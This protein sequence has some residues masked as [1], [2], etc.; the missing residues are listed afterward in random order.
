MV[1]SYIDLARQLNM[2]NLILIFYNNQ[3]ELKILREK[4]KMLITIESKY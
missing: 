4:R 1:Q 2:S 3:L